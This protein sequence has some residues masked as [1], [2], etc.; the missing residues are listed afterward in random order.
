MHLQSSQ[1]W[2][3]QLLV[4]KKNN[5]TYCAPYGVFLQPFINPKRHQATWNFLVE[6]VGL[7]GSTY[8]YLLSISYLN[9]NYGAHTISYNTQ[10]TTVERRSTQTTWQKVTLRTILS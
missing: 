5:F 3:K 10:Y 9:L 6:Q 8:E 2:K 1:H 4:P 7:L